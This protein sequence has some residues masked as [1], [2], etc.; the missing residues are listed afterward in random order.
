M[1]PLD[2]IIIIVLSFFIVYGIVNGLFQEIA[3][4]VGL[5][6]GFYIAYH[7]YP[8][9]AAL[10]APILSDKFNA[11]LNLLGFVII[12]CMFFLM[13]YILGVGIKYLIKLASLGWLDRILGGCLGFLKGLIVCSILLFLIKTISSETSPIIKES[14]LSPHISILS[15]MMI[16]VIPKNVNQEF[17]KQIGKIENTWKQLN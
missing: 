6:G 10:L 2:I 1:N 3:S 12:F 11:Y 8:K 7:F 14:K 9:G 15:N 16:S 17:H 13:V 4:I 5:I